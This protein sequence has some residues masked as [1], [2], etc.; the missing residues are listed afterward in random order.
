[1]RRADPKRRLLALALMALCACVD[2]VQEGLPG[3]AGGCQTTADCPVPFFCDAGACEEVA[4]ASACDCPAP[5]GCST[6]SF[7]CA[8]VP[9]RP[10]DG[11][12]P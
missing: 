4:C 7:V 1:M 12:C 2:P 11:G 6:L 5:Y 3:D 8:P 10:P 9:R